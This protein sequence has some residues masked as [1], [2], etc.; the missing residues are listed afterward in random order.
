L[1]VAWIFIY[2]PGFLIV[3]LSSMRLIGNEGKDIILS[4]GS[5]KFTEA[6]RAA[7]QQ[8]GR[9]PATA[10]DNLTLKQQ[11]NRVVGNYFR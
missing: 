1:F 2:L 7:E 9:N 5:K 6:L 3:H 8:D 11:L 10:D 4:G